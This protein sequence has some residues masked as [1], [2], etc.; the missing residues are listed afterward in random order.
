M[1]K[2]CEFS[3][4][5]YIK[6]IKETKLNRMILKNPVNTVR[7]SFTSQIMINVLVEDTIGLLIKILSSCIQNNPEPNFDI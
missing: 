1:K 3:T 7:T 5:V 6:S 4:Q 2:N